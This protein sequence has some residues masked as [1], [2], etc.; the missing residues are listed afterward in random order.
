MATSETRDGPGWWMASDGGW[1]PPEM[2]PESTPPLPGWVR[3]ADG[4]WKAP[5]ERPPEPESTDVDLSQNESAPE[6]IDLTVQRVA[7][8]ASPSTTGATIAR[9]GKTMDLPAA[10]EA[11]QLEQSLRMGMSEPVEG[12]T[13]DEGRDGDSDDGRPTLGFAPPTPGPAPNPATTQRSQDRDPRVL[14]VWLTVAILACIAGL[15]AVLV[16]L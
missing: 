6:V 4:S 12:D 11:P 10:K 7:A 8:D 13:G 5:L 14:A 15:L 16:L 9:G 1:N 3:Q 2:W